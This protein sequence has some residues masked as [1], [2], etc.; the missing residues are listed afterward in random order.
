MTM[1]GTLNVALKNRFCGQLSW[2]SERNRFT[3]RYAPEYLA[4]PTA[5]R[6]SLS[7]P[8]QSEPFDEDVSYP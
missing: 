5:E 6:L 1:F 4:D 3:F 8:L 2:E 7:L